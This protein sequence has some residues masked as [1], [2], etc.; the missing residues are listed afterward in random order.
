MDVTDFYWSGCYRKHEV[1]SCRQS[2]EQDVAQSF[3]R[4]IASC[5]FDILHNTHFYITAPGFHLWLTKAI[6]ALSSPT[7]LERSDPFISLAGRDKGPKS[8]NRSRER[9]LPKT[10]EIVFSC[11]PSMVYLGPDWK[12]ATFLSL[13]QQLPRRHLFSFLPSPFVSLA[14][15]RKPLEIGQPC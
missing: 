15:C 2:A 7:Q 12:V 10:L 11:V 1:Q 3:W 8:E 14:W 5:A 13:L 6:L 9:L 4:E